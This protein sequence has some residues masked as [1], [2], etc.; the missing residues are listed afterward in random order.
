MTHLLVTV[1]LASLLGSLHCAG[2][3]GGLVAFYSG[4]GSCSGGVHSRHA[5]YSLGRLL[6][7]GLLGCVAGGL[8]ASVDWAGS[9][10]GIQGAGAW[11]AGVLLLVWGTVSLFPALRRRIPEMVSRGFPQ[12]FGAAVRRI[13]GWGAGSRALTLGLLSALLPCGW[14]YAFVLCAAGTG[15]LWSGGAVMGV[16]WL[17][18]LPM[19][20]GLGYGVQLLSR[21]FLEQL[22][23]VTALTLIGMG[24]FTV[25]GRFDAIGLVPERPAVESQDPQASADFVKELDSSELPC[26]QGQ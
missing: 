17:G 13:R 12:V 11:A 7:Y 16:F 21:R 5:L 6:S 8:G 14:L 4:T 23:K 9:S 25:W 10:T 22:P 1:L 26:C 15:G 3:C 18:T 24:I 2:M 20:L 19:L